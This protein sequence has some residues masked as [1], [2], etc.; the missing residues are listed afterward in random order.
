MDIKAYMQD[1][2][3]AARAASRAVARADTNTKNKALAAMAQANQRDA[4]KLLSAN[5]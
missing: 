5:A 3:R 4:E 2:G 1:I